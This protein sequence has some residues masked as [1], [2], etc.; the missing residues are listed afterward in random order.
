MTSHRATITVLSAP[1]L[2]MVASSAALH[3]EPAIDF[4]RDIAPIFEQHCIRCHQPTNKKGELSLATA[5]ELIGNQYVV[6]GDSD[7]S[8]LLEVLTASA[9][10]RPLMPKEGTPL[11]DKDVATLRAWITEGAAW[12][13][14]VVVKQRSKADRNW[15]SLQPLV[16]NEPPPESIPAEWAANAIDRFIFTKL[17]A[18]GLQPNPPADRRTL[19]RRVTY[20]LTGLPPTIEE[21]AAF[22][23]DTSADAYEKLIDRLLASPRYGEHWGRHWL[24]VVRFG[25]STGFEVNHIID[26]AWPYRDY[27]I[28]SLN[29]DKPFDQFVIEHLAGDAVGQGDP[30]VEVGLT[31]LVCGPHDIVGNQ[32]AMKAAQI[33]AD[34][35]DEIIRATG[36]AFLGLTVGCARC[37]DHKFDPITQR[38][39]YSLY[40]TFAGV[41]PDDR[42]VAPEAQ[43]RDRT[44]RLAPLED[45]KKR[46]L[47]EKSAQEHKATD[48]ERIESLARRLAELEQQ[49]ANL[50][51]LPRLRVGRFEQ[52]KGPQC[53]FE[54]GDA[55]RKGETV[56]PAS[57]STL[58]DAAQ[59]YSLPPDAPERER[60]L[61]FA[62]WIVADDNPL[63]PRVLVNRLW[64]HHF[65]AGIVATPNDFGYMGQR[66]SHP[67]LLDW[68]AARL[69]VN[70]WKLKPIH[71]MIVMSQ[72]YRQSSAFREPAAAID[73]DSRLLW[74]FPPR[75][76]SAEEVRDTVLL[77]AG[78]LDERRGG[79]GFRLYE[80]TRDNVAT[81]IPLETFGPE[82]YRRSVYHQ[83]ARAS[84]VDL[85]SDFDAPDC[86]LSISRRVPTTTPTQALALMNH[87][88]TIQMAES[89]AARLRNETDE[90]DPIAQIDRAFNL[91]FGRPPATEEIESA[92][93]LVNQHGLRTFCRALLNA[94]E[95]IYI[96]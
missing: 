70:G 31:F 25:E 13:E 53:V 37:H 78:K 41:F 91:A 20:D 95:L 86:A 17:T 30:A 82:T 67:A 57:L 73:A 18:T 60:R 19:I 4:T 61:A 96:D 44:E 66:P 72:A 2:A 40:A 24:D 77:L 11:S 15:W 36:E 59:A 5:D 46:R 3:A 26:N 71:K 94:S 9:G 87:S 39:Y 75:R 28:H 8:R 56:V 65:G 49:I 48:R 90:G 52:P 62:R 7:A 93:A 47:Q 38:D 6:P 22:D 84:R 68:L 14:D 51:A 50:P 29:D 1:L 55:N 69:R 88:F 35:V 74:R 76:L 79:A 42:V 43:L 89:L 32:D 58:A 21:T 81:Y 27:V 92:G 83:N 33:R 45:A 23:A 16:V 85:L 54:R 10:E 63:T 12:P 80:Y 34:T 64:Q